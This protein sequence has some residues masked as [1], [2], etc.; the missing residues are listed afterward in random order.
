MNEIYFVSYDMKV[1]GRRTTGFYELDMNAALHR[2][3]IVADIAS[4]QLEHV[5]EVYRG[6]EDEKTFYKVTHEIAEEVLILCRDDGREID[7]HLQSW[8][9]NKVGIRAV[10]EAVM[11]LAS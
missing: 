5:D 10:N 2:K 3:T 1:A 7:G 6:S 11:D 8:L 9:E 4:G